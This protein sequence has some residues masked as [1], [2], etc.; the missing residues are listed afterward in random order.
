MSNIEPV[1]RLTVQTI[2]RFSLDIIEMILNTSATFRV[3]CYDTN[4]K[5]VETKFVT[6]EGDDYVNWGN[7]DDY[8]TEFVATELGFT[9]V[10]YLATIEISEI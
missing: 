6:L 4:D 8:V 9:L 1:E 5:I 10:P 2:V 3:L 7:D